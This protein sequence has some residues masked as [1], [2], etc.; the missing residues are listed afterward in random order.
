MIVLVNMPFAGI[1]RPS[2]SLGL[3]KA[4]LLKNGFRV[5]VLDLNLEMASSMGFGK[6]HNLTRSNVQFGDWFFASRAFDWGEDSS[7]SP[8]SFMESYGLT[9]PD[10]DEWRENLLWLNRVR[11]ELVPRFLERAVQMVT[12]LKPELVGFSCS[13]QQTTSSLA[14]GR[15]LS[16][17]IPG[18]P[19]LFGGAAMHGE[20]GLAFIEACPWMSAVVTGEAEEII[21]SLVRALLLRQPR[22]DLP[23]VIFSLP[24]DE[25]IEG[26][27]PEPVSI[28]KFTANPA[29]DYDD[30]FNVAEHFGITRDKGW[31]AEA[32]LPVETSRGCWWGEK[33]QCR[34]CGLN[35]VGMK[36]RC[37]NPQKAL[38][39]FSVLLEKYPVSRLY[40]SDNNLSE[41]YFDTLLPVLAA[42]NEKGHHWNIFYSIKGGLDEKAIRNLA[43]A[44]IRDTG[45]GI[46]SLSTHL[47]QLMGKGVN[48][49]SNI[50]HLRMSVKYGVRAR[51]NLLMSIPGENASDY[52][53]MADLIPLL[54]HLYPPFGA[55]PVLCYR[56]SPYF[57]DMEKYC[58]SS[59][60]A[61]FYRH[62]F[63][64]AIVNIDRA[65]FVYDVKWRDV[66]SS[67]SREPVVKAVELWRKGWLNEEPP[68]LWYVTMDVP[69]AALI[70][71]QTDIQTDALKGRAPY[72]IDGRSVLRI[73]ELDPFQAQV[74]DFIQEPVTLGD[75]SAFAELQ[76]SDPEKILKCIDD[77]ISDGLAIGEGGRF[78]ALAILRCDPSIQS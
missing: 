66:V 78:L 71:L 41:D 44:G 11:E 60:P 48:L 72:I 50:H 5:M 49:I 70:D 30:F 76:N 56:F 14:L 34:F 57:R 21:E 47:L 68:F 23:G 4:I 19:L 52:E 12:S 10:S 54:T 55:V 18:I 7:G 40:A 58:E 38:Q 63:P 73:H 69:A 33:C 65:A 53:A 29:P 36:Y 25:I 2:L 13:F 20:M 15:L 22:N 24:C 16:A 39:I 26:P 32:W 74:Y 37:M 27:P 43:L 45:P 28:E 75:V 8:E 31:L 51:W 1:E 46:E 17:E 77:F 3:L 42:Q 9:V 59:E 35:G 61:A 64:Q 6:Y 67:M 62:L